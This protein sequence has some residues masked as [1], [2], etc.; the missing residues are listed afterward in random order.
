M[1][2]NTSPMTPPRYHDLGQGARLQW[3]PALLPDDQATHLL[4]QLTE[5]LAWQQPQVRV[6]GR[7]H[8][9]PRLTCWHGEAGIRYRYSGLEHCATGWPVILQPLHDAIET[10]TGKMFNS[11][12]GNLYRDG[13]DSMGYHSDDES[14][15]G[16]APWIASYSLGVSRD[17]VF[18]PKTG[19]HRRQCFS[20]PLGHNQLLL[21]N[22][23]VQ[24]HFQ[25]ALPRRAGVNE[26]RINLTFRS[27]QAKNR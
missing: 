19:S 27:I 9:V 26:L 17:F 22:P 20:L 7:I 3:W 12:L 21:M 2:V 8:T 1:S 14:E 15:L 6:Y 18:R 24:Q 16:N 13:R 11:M 10:C 5:A 4:Q 25:H 23:A